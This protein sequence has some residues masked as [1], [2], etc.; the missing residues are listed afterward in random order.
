MRLNDDQ[1]QALWFNEL[2]DRAVRQTS[3]ASEVLAVAQIA[4]SL[5]PEP[6]EEF[7]NGLLFQE[8]QEAFEAA[9]SIDVPPQ[10]EQYRRRPLQGWAG[11]GP[12]TVGDFPTEPVGQGAGGAHDPSPEGSPPGKAPKAARGGKGRGGK[13]RT[14]RGLPRDLRLGKRLRLMAKRRK[15]IVR[16]EPT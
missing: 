2:L 8:A 10:E 7:V 9:L 14:K 3:D 13:A 1:R 16:T 4:F 15:E 5:E 6:P 12:V 11:I